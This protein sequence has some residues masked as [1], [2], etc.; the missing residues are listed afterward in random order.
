M[1]TN[2]LKAAVAVAVTPVTAVVDVVMF[3]P[4]ACSYR[5]EHDVPFSRTGAMLKAAG[6][7][8]VDAIKSERR[9]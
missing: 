8:V 3:I 1:L 2:L 4:D 5:P 6:E 7:S 9:P